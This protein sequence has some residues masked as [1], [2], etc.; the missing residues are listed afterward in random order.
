[1][2]TSFSELIHRVSTLS[3]KFDNTSLL[4][5]N[6]WVLVNETN[7]KK[8]LYIFRDN[9]ELIISEDGKVD[10]ALWRYL[11]KNTLL[12]EK[13]NVKNLYKHEFF[14]QNLIAI[15]IRDDQNYSFFVNEEKF[16]QGLN[17]ENEILKYLH[18]KYLNNE[19]YKKITR[20]KRKSLSNTKNSGFYNYNFRY[21]YNYN[22]N[23]L[24]KINNKIVVLKNLKKLNSLEGLGF[25]I[26]VLASFLP[27]AFFI[28]YFKTEVNIFLLGFLII[29][30]LSLKKIIENGNL[31]FY[32]LTNLLISYTIVKFLNFKSETLIDFYIIGLNLV[33]ILLLNNIFIKYIKS[34]QTFLLTNVIITFFICVLAV[35][36]KAQVLFFVNLCVLIP[37]ICFLF[38]KKLNK[39]KKHEILITQSGQLAIGFFLI[40]S[41]IY[42]L[43]LFL[44]I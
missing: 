38:Y 39:N 13:K 42:L 24:D 10:V 18:N 12:I 1:M 5:N 44:Y 43:K 33:L 14:D 25:Y 35:V 29:L 23:A 27:I 28:I 3:Q 9:N 8:E 34:E 19:T 41:V 36:N 2:E 26:F 15:K 21:N 17:S 4:F 37:S 32:F 40:S 7:S 20:R 11:G 30:V 16:N 6:H 31:L 22:Y